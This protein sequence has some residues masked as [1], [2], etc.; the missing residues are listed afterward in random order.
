MGVTRGVDGAPKFT[1]PPP[2]N[3]NPHPRY[4]MEFVLLD[5]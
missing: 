5:L 1:P 2:P 4:L 3:P